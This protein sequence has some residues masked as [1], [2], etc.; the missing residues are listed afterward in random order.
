M[1]NLDLTCAQFGR[2]LAKIGDENLLTSALAVL[3]EQGLYAFFLFLNVKK[4]DSPVSRASSEF[5]RKTPSN[6]HVL[7]K[8]TGDIF[9]D[10][11]TLSENLDKLLLARDLLIQALV[12]AR[13]HAKTTESQNK[14]KPADYSR[15]NS[16]DSQENKDIKKHKVEF[17]S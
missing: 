8:N 17:S 16:D 15:G 12:Y 13:Y 5:L 7:E 11:Q 3:E 14:N 10:L 1:E 4:K 9:H 2:K 6:A